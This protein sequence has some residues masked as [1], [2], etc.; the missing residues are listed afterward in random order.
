MNLST[1]DAHLVEQLFLD[2][3][4]KEVVQRFDGLQ[5]VEPWASLYVDAIHD[6]R[7][8]DAVW[9]RYHI[10]GEVVDGL[11]EGKT[12]LERITED[13]MGYKKYAPEQYAE[14]VSFY[15][16]ASSTDVHTD[17]IEVILRIDG[18]DL[19]GINIPEDG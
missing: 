7:F 18:E 6:S 16:G 9:A 14:A 15:R 3:S 1:Q 17:V 4:V 13:A 10:F 8:G 11:Y 12:I 2:L 5:L 19:T